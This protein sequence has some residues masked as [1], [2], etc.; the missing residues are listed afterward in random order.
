[1]GIGSDLRALGCFLDA[2]ERRGETVASVDVAET[3]GESPV[4][5]RADVE[6]V[7]AVDLTE[8]CEAG[9]V[10]PRVGPDG[11][12]RFAL[13]AAAEILPALDA[14]AADHDVAVEPADATM[15]DGQLRLTVAATVP[16]GSAAAPADAGEGGSATADRDVSAA[17]GARGGA[18]ANGESPDDT[19]G[20]AADEAGTVGSRDSDVPPFEDPDLLADVYDANDTFAEMAEALDM[21][22]TAE[23]VRRYMIDFDIHEPDTYQTGGDGSRNG[24]GSRSRNGSESE[25][26]TGSRSGNGSG[27]GTGRGDASGNGTGPDDGS[28]AGVAAAAGEQPVV[29]SDGI[30]LPEDV[31]VDAFIETVQ[32]SNTI[33]EVKQDID[34][35]RTDALE[36][37]Q[38]LNLLDLVVGRLATETERDITREDVVER[39]RAASDEG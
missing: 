12:L 9:L 20:T 19:A 38:D 25:S 26:E 24:D 5:L 15:V 35:E 1:M 11:T 32:R 23:T 33:Y 28:D 36:M 22:V 16:A 14:G 27:T 31:T 3:A 29:L 8:A 13:A 21:G 7:T 17:A 4:R 34:V 39:L 10:D 37:L 2:C 30:G 6:L 18:A